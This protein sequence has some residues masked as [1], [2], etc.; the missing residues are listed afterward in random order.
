[1]KREESGEICGWL[2][3]DVGEGEGTMMSVNKWLGMAL[4]LLS[5]V[6]AWAGE[7]GLLA[8]A[9]KLLKSGNAAE[10]Y[11]VLAPHQS[12]R[13]GDPAYDYLFGIAALDS[14]K[15]NE[16]IFAL[17]RVLA[18]NPGHLQ[19]RAE[20]ARAYYAVGEV[21]TSQQEF[22]TVR[23]QNP[24]EGVSAT[25]DKFLD[26]IDK[27]RAGE[28]TTVKGYL[29]AAVGDDSNV[30]NAT[31]SSTTF[32]GGLPFVLPAT[33]VK[34]HD[35][36]TSVAAGFSVR[37][38]Y[39]PE[40][41]VFGGAN[42][43]QRFN[44][45]KDIYD[46]G[47]LDG[48]LG[49]GLTK[50]DNI[51]TAALQMQTF[52]FDNS[53]YRDANGIIA[54]WQRNLDKSSQFSAYFQYTDLHYPRPGMDVR[55]ADRYLLGAAYAHALGGLYTPVVYIGAYAG[56]EAEQMAN[57]PYNGHKFYGARAGG[58]MKVN[59]QTALFGS[60]SLESRDYGGQ[61]PFFLVGR[62][63][64]QADLKIGVNYSPANN[65]MITP[66]LSYTRNDS[67]IAIDDYDR[68]LFSVSLR[69]NFN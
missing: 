1:M 40:W 14:G 27:A 33:A 23:K 18:V 3:Y 43:N 16:A 31:A 35:S 38:P 12:E 53:R 59:P 64:T 65:W 60:A 9:D 5:C 46:T 11:T 62:N 15:P 13:A 32:I 57:V 17:E 19:A 58:E 67:N 61:D 22:E 30:N 26:A 37:H 54:Q 55:D 44:S 36:F 10:A 4:L 45:S 56:E 29:E 52:S 21:A 39:T 66:Q 34:Q 28:K 48:N 7:D 49:V 68:T 50:G 2:D 24:P 41:S 63:D 8:E 69:R 47:S 42:V 6:G 25:I 20:I 51:Y